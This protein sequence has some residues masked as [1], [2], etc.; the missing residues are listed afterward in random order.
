[1]LS[2]CGYKGSLYLPD[3]NVKVEE[4]KAMQQPLPQYYR[5]LTARADELPNAAIL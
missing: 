1:M 5:T 4:K 3:E 2:A